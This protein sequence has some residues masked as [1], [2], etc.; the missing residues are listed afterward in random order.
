MELL[1]YITKAIELKTDQTDLAHALGVHR[2]V[3]THAKAGRR[4]LPTLACVKLAQLIGEDE[5]RVI[6]ASELVTEKNP[7]RRAVWLPF[8]QEIA[9]AAMKSTA[10]TVQSSN[11]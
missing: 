3:L 10:R 9:A 8:V 4:G 7:E 6:A 2:D 11:L 1:A 5:R